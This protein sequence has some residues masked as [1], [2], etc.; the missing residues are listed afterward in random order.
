[1]LPGPRSGLSP[2]PALTMFRLSS[3]DENKVHL[4]CSRHGCD[5]RVDREPGRHL[6]RLPSSVLLRS[7]TPL[8]TNLSVHN[9][10]NKQ[11][12]ELTTV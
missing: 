6:Q 3:G 10:A 9:P 1:M 8:P 2:A 11:K 7:R 5:P 4:F 12:D